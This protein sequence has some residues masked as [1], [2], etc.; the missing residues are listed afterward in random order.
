MTIQ[1]LLKLLPGGHLTWRE[2][3]HENEPEPYENLRMNLD[4]LDCIHIEYQGPDGEWH[5]W[6]SGR[7]EGKPVSMFNR[8]DTEFLNALISTVE[9]ICGGGLPEEVND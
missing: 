3:P 1:E 7:I 6:E 8:S 4:Q 9:F 2:G 5:E